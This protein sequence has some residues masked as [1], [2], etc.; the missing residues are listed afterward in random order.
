VPKISNYK[1]GDKMSLSIKKIGISNCL[2][3]DIK[4]FSEFT[5][6]E[7]I[8]LSECM[9][10]IEQIISVIV[11]PRIVSLKTIQTVKGVS[12]E[13]HYL[14]GKK[15]AVE[16]ELRQKILYA[17]DINEQT[18]HIIENIFFQIAY[19]VVPSFIEGTEIELL[20]KHKR[21]NA[22]L[23]IEDISINKINNREIFKTI[24]LLIRCKFKPTYE[25]CFSQYK[26]YENSNIYMCYE[27]GINI[28]NI[29]SD[30]MY[31]NLLPLWSPNGQ[32][33]AFLSNKDENFMLYIYNINTS[34][35]SKITDNKK[36][37]CITSFC[38][39][40]KGNNLL[41]SGIIDNEKEIFLINIRT[42][43]CKQLTY[44]NGLVRSFKP[45]VSFN[46]SK[47]AYLNSCA[48]INNLCLMD[49]TGLNN[50]Q[51]TNCYY[52]SDFNWCKDNTHIVYIS[53]NKLKNDE[54]YII[55]ITNLRN[56]L[57][58][59]PNCI[60]NI[61]KVKFSPDCKYVSFIGSD[62]IKKNMY[63]YELEENTITKLTDNNEDVSISD[64]VWNTDGT[65]MYFSCDYLG[66]F[67][68]YC[69]ELENNCVYKITNTTASNIEL[70]YRP[71]IK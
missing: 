35:P 9:P 12:A 1:G 5:S 2:D 65:K 49:I 56:K 13:G 54:L 6:T 32:D 34:I 21:L 31:K 64:Y 67:N 29:T 8:R 26:N 61:K 43:H 59:I 53:S 37:K 50:Q 7:I 19:I 24:F 42:L 15:I 46:G 44:G 23:F 48:N 47:V 17:A 36:F 51:L 40:H 38:W 27:K 41:F 33:I 66:Y 60:R 58:E 52:V 68:I 22:K 16:I 18:V 20:L 62:H 30:N 70:D 10:D 4:F 55:N 3:K 69:L 63:I 39:D 45:K 14:T 71:R 11:E 25:L 28:K 57:V